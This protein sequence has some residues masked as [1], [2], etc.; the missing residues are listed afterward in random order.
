MITN[1]PE[2]RP[3]P[4]LKGYGFTHTG[5]VVKE[6]ACYYRHETIG[7][8]Q[9]YYFT[10]ENYLLPILFQTPQ[11]LV[12]DGFSPNL[13]KRLH[14]G[15]LRNLCVAL[16]LSRTLPNSKMV[17]L[18]GA[19]LGILDGVE[20]ELYDLLKFVGYEVNYIKDI[21]LDVPNI[22]GNITT[23]GKGDKTG[24]KVFGEKEVVIIRSNSKPTY[25]GYELA[26]SLLSK[27]SIDYYITGWEQADHFEFLGLKDK[28]LPI[29]LVLGL[30]GKKI[31]SRSGDSLKLFEALTIVEN[32]LY[33]DGSKDESINYKELAWNICCFNLLLTSRAK[34]IQ[35]VPEQ[36]FK[37]TSPG[38]YCS[39]TFARL[40]SIL[41]RGKPNTT[42][43][44]PNKPVPFQKE[45]IPYVA[46]IGYLVW[47]RT[48]ASE[49]LDP[50]PLANQ[51]LKTCRFINKCLEQEKII[52]NRPSLY[53]AIALLNDFLLDS[54]VRLGMFPLDR[55]ST[56]K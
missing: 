37:I 11:G 9:N 2:V 39:Y 21:D 56:R 32:S 51:V 13:N 23:E 7:I 33:E 54:M 31:K 6:W 5:D 46:Q 34:N 35:F 41:Q 45:D 20:E 28:H 53:H 1:F 18:L 50:A 25:A 15:H 36:Q 17:G 44:S 52:G 14:I 27:E 8:Y 40:S 12:I 29:G 10:P 30:D 55:V 49:L 48:R 24:C 3:L 22:V 19:S 38:L 4:D 42:D 16:S 43:L 26:F 47:A